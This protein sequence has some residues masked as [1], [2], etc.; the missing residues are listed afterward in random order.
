MHRLDFIDFTS[1]KHLHINLLIPKW[2]CEFDK[3]DK[4]KFADFFLFR[5]TVHA[6]YSIAVY[7]FTKINSMR[8]NVHPENYLFK[9][10]NDMHIFNE[11]EVHIL[12]CYK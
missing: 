9:Y 4:L 7:L 8:N 2:S 11:G 6:F 10:A 5:L 1:I 3:I 12:S